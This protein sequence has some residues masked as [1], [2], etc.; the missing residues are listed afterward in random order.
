MQLWLRY[1]DDTFTAVQKD[2]IDAFYNHLHE[3]NADT[4]FTR[5]IELNGKRPFSDCLV[6][7]DNNQNDSVRETNAFRQITWRIILQPTSHKAT[8][9]KTLTNSAQL[10]CDILDRLRDEN[11]YLKRVY[12]ADFIRLNID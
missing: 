6:S 12:N 8:A 4:L 5:E 10:F 11:S 7:H 9:I 3:Q 2:E 1:V